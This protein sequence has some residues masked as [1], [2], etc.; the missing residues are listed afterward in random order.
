MESWWKSEHLEEKG[1][2]V[3]TTIKTIVFDPIVALMVVKCAMITIP[4]TNKYTKG[5][6]VYICSNNC[7]VKG[8]CHAGAERALCDTWPF[9][10]S[11]AF[12]VGA[13]VV[14][15]VL[16]IAVAKKLGLYDPLHDK[17]MDKSAS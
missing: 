17:V 12:V 10:A 11:N 2:K 15:E 9:F 5:D 14:E 3:E 16:N 8:A 7:A 4:A 6:L 1:R 13:L